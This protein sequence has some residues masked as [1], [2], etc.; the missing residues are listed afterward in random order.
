MKVDQQ[1][2][3]PIIVATESAELVKR[4][5]M[6]LVYVGARWEPALLLSLRAGV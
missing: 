6:L 5:R 4:Q 1:I 2:L 3:E